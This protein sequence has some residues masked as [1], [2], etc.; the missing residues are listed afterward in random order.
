MTV[1]TIP[2]VIFADKWGRRTSLITGGLLLSSTC[3]VISS[4]SAA[5]KV[6]SGS[7]AAYS[8]IVLI[9][10]F[11]LTY[12]V[13][14]AIAGKIYASEIQPT[15]T[16]ASANC[17]AQALGFF[18][19]ETSSIYFFTDRLSS[20]R[21]GLSHSLLPYSSPARHMGRTSCMVHCQYPWWRF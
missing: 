4:L 12:C 7:P 2:A 21:T 18:S 6:T 5:G 19:V 11:A 1:V 17:V 3:Y 10:L 8:I 13:T 15:K 9:F 20:S 14:W 16:R